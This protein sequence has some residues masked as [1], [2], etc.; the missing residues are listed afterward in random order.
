MIDK[1]VHVRG[2]PCDG[3]I[4]AIRADARVGERFQVYIP[5]VF[6]PDRPVYLPYDDIRN[7]PAADVAVYTYDGAG[8]I[9]P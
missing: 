1:I 2:G 6:D 9:A 4:H 7:S 3:H 5:S 8:L